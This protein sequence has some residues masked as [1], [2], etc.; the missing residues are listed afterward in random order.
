MVVNFESTTGKFVQRRQI[1]LLYEA[2]GI[3]H[4]SPGEFIALVMTELDIPY[5]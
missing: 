2:H 1:I 3:V 5:T 4:E